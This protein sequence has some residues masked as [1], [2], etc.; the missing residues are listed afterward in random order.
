MDLSGIPQ[1]INGWGVLAFVSLIAFEIFLSLKYEPEL[2]QWKDFGG[3][4]F[5]GFGSVIVAIGTKALTIWAFFAVYNLFNPTINGE[6]ANIVF[7]SNYTLL[8]DWQN[9]VNIF[10]WHAFGFAWYMFLICQVL[11]DFNYY[12]HHRLSHTVRVLWAAHIVHHSS[13]NFNLG[14]GIRNGWVTLVY[15]PIFWMWLPAIGFHPYMVLICLAVQS[16]WQFQLHTKFVPYMGFLEK[17]LNTHKQ[18]QVHHA[19]NVEYM[20]KNH[21]G[22][23]NI[24]DKL[25]GTHEVLQEDT[26]DIKFGVVHPPKT[27]NPIDIFSHE[28]VDIWRDVKSTP[29]LKDKL[30]YIFGPPGWMPGDSSQTV[31]NMQREI[32]KRRQEEQRAG[33]MPVAV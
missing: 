33:K 16:L 7:G 11:D 26:V 6:G 23:L 17:F 2:Y 8:P 31:R 25:F 15:K 5:M 13:N 27:N 28:Y 3:S 22:Y 32:K 9:R 24:F 10:G 29:K 1:L 21:G 30:M 4:V 12:W 18:H 20:D 14:S 19:Q